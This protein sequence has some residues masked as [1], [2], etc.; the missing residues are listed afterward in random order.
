MLEMMLAPHLTPRPSA[1]EIAKP[2]KRTMNARGA[3]KLLEWL[4]T[5]EG[6]TPTAEE[7]E[8]YVY[9]RRRYRWSIQLRFVYYQ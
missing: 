1:S 9:V 2:D 7:S 6:A 5:P 4:Q 3:A 8:G